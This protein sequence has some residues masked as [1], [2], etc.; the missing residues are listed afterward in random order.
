MHRCALETAIDAIP[1]DIHF[2]LSEESGSAI[3]LVIWTFTG[4]G[5]PSRMPAGL[6]PWLSMSFMSLQRIPRCFWQVISRN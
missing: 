5:K 4:S 6:Y 3:P 2:V 1:L